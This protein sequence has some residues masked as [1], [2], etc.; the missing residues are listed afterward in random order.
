MSD[1]LYRHRPAHVL[2]AGCNTGHFSLLAAGYGARVVAIDWDPGAVGV[3]WSRAR[4]ADA[5]VLPLV[6][7]LAAPTPALGWENAESES[8]LA[9]ARGRFDCV[10]ML[11][12]LHHLVVSE[13]I[14]LERILD[15]AAGLTTDLLV[16]EFVA[17]DDSQ[18]LKIAR[19]REGLHRDWSP[20]TFEYAVQQRFD[21][22]EQ[23]AVSSTRRVY[24][25]RKLG[26]SFA[27]AV[28]PN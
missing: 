4:A 19:G 2:D 20:A 1:T 3:V 14:P 11:G 25:L 12:L 8:F 26:S 6:V 27:E 16:L 15:L 23:C 18:F 17:A 28:R 13:R 10:L 7:N 9:R 22:L 21:I 24:T 5:A